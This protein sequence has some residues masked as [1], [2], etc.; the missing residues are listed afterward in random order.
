MSG[1]LAAREYVSRVVGLAAV[2]TSANAEP[3]PTALVALACSLEG[4]V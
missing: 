2:P 3:L 4:S 1:S